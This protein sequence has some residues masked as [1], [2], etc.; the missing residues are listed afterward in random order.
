MLL[1]AFGLVTA[2]VALH[3]ESTAMRGSQWIVMIAGL[4]GALASGCTV[5]FVHT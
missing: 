4:F 1:C 3:R 2:F 5:A